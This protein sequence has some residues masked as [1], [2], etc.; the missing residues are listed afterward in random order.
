MSTITS[1]NS[2]FAIIIPGVYSAPQ[3]I[4]GYAMDDAFSTEAIEKA[5]VK[6]GID[7]KLSA[8]YIFNPYKMTITLQADSVSFPIFTNWQLAQDA[9]R[10]IIGASAT[11]IIPSIG[12]KFAMTNGYMT[13]FQAMPE[14]KKTL[15]PAKFEIS[16]EKIVGAKVS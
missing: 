14:A 7:G 4:Q 1:A 15:D 13:R 6:M 10:E 11:I 12:Y 3:S 5:E 9:V 8:G 2:S 16:W